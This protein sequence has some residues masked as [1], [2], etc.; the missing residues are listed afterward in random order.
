[1]TSNPYLLKMKVIYA[2]HIVLVIL[3]SYFLFGK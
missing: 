2:L 3:L 1:M